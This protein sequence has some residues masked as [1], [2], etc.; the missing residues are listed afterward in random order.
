[1]PS[2]SKGTI[3]L[4][5]LK[6]MMMFRKLIANSVYISTLLEQNGVKIDFEEPHLYPL[7]QFQS[8]RIHTTIYDVLAADSQ[9]QS[10][11]P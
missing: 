3:I 11:M 8:Y 4:L 7:S 1:M 6:L 9:M 10:E 2:L 5:V